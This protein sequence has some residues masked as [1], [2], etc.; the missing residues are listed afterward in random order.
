MRAE[1]QTIEVSPEELRA[2]VGRVERGELEQGD[3][4]LIRAMVEMILG[5]KTELEEKTVSIKRL[6]RIV[7]GSTSEKTK[8]VLPD[9]E[10]EQSADEKTK[11][12]DDTEQN[13]PEKEKGKEKEKKKPKGHGRNGNGKYTGVERI[14][15]DH[16]ELKPGDPCP[17]CPAGTLYEFRGNN[18]VVKLRLIGTAPVQGKAYELQSLRCNLCQEIFTAAMPEGSGDEKYRQIEGPISRGWFDFLWSDFK[19]L[20][21]ELV[22]ETL[23]SRRGDLESD[24]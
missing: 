4:Q 7:F 3:V 24:L 17:L 6:Q 1:Q 11:D 21:L 2:L 20:S 13:E 15:V 5:F 16:A 19:V 10:S 8:E 12:G 22:P 23:R 14:R 18:P 9:C